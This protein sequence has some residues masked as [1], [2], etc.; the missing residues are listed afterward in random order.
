M[1]QGLQAPEKLDRLPNPHRWLH[2]G[3]KMDKQKARDLLRDWHTSLRRLLALACNSADAAVVGGPQ[4]I[5]QALLKMS[6]LYQN[7]ACHTGLVLTLH[8]I[9]ELLQVMPR[10]LLHRCLARNCPM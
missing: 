8:D 9:L 1:L 4:T 5:I 7:F 3:H 2:K 6:S 10:L